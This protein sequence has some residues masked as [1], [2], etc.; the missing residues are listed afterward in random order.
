MNTRVP[1]C[2][3]FVVVV[4]VFESSEPDELDRD[5]VDEVPVVHLFSY[6]SSRL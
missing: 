2:V 1:W 4:V 6:C 3:S 5:I